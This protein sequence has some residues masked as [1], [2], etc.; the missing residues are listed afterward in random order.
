MGGIVQKIAIVET[1]CGSTCLDLDRWVYGNNKNKK[2]KQ[3][4]KFW[5]QSEEKS[6]GNVVLE[7]SALNTGGFQQRCV[8]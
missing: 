8:D 5:G 3:K 6:L 1:G 2:I 7:I 4:V